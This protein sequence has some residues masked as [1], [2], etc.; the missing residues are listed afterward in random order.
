MIHRFSLS[1][2]HSV[3]EKI[4]VD[5][6][7]DDK[8]P[9]SNRYTRLQ[10]GTRVS[11]VQALIGPNA[12][13]KTTALRALSFLSWL[14]TDSFPGN[15]YETELPYKPFAGNRDT[16]KP[17]E[18]F[19]D[20]EI[21]GSVY[22]YTVT[23]NQKNI[24][25]E[26]LSVRSLATLRMTTKKLFSRK[27]DQ[28]REN[29]VLHDNG[30]DLPGG[31]WQSKELGRTSI[32][33]VAYKFGHEQASEIFNYWDDCVLTNVDIY[34]SYF[35]SNRRGYNVYD[36]LRYFGR[37]ENT[38][39]RMERETKIY[40]DFGISSIGN[41]MIRHRYGN[42]VEFELD[43]EEES[44]GT[45]SFM[46]ISRMI[47]AVLR[48]GGIAVVDEFDAYLHPRMFASL[49]NK[50]FDTKINIGRGQLLMTTHN[51]NIFNL[52]DPKQQLLLVEKND[53]GSTEVRYIRGRADANHLQK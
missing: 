16:G 44:S 9:Q 51:L 4:T 30:F 28:D 17:S 35:H 53:Q 15:R 1:N 31:Y 6:V 13:G 5:F 22:S 18:L 8:A 20:F 12:A 46:N 48:D 24:L 42:G 49:I 7:V 29:Y 47:D 3:D 10:S 23:F 34:H 26:E 11:L 43:P 41:E 52:I 40:A 25:S 50:F 19:I 14:V 38:K 39:K 36:A 2:F 45:V 32:I 21:S 37:D 33:N 27:W